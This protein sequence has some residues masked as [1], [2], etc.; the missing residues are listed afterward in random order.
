[1]KKILTP[2][3][4]KF[5]VGLDLFRIL[6]FHFGIFPATA[7]PVFKTKSLGVSLVFCLCLSICLSVCLSLSL[8][9]SLSRSRSSSLALALALG[10][11]LSLSEPEPETNSNDGDQP[12]SGR[13]KAILLDTVNCLFFLCVRMRKVQ[14]RH[15]AYPQKEDV[16][17]WCTLHFKC[18]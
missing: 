15:H 9:I 6:Q 5:C 7:P 17:S 3:I 14:M 10:L 13:A 2:A 12:L 4:C 1:M 8:S 11:A 16:V 18:F